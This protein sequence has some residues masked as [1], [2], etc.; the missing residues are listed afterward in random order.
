MSE[1]ERALEEEVQHLTVVVERLREVVEEYAD[2]QSWRCQW[3][4][5][6]PQTPDCP[7][8]LITALAAVEV[9]DTR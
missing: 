3:P 1:R 8:G 6:Y 7:C 5:R 4:D 2:H 9:G